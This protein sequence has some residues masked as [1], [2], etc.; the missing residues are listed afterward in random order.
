VD[1]K[2]FQI[3]SWQAL[4]YRSASKCDPGRLRESWKTNSRCHGTDIRKA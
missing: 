2:H 4:I 1:R 3:F